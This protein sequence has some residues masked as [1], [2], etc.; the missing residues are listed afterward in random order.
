ML[1]YLHPSTLQTDRPTEVTFGCRY[2]TMYVDIVCFLNQL[3]LPLY[4][5]GNLASYNFFLTEKPFYFTTE[6]RK[7]NFHITFLSFSSNSFNDRNYRELNGSFW[8]FCLLGG[9][10]ILPFTYRTF[11]FE[12]S[13]FS[14]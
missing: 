12:N 5:C 13:V 1:A 7:K 10:R 11:I 8:S 6:T 2:S 4:N 9:V 14:S 3:F